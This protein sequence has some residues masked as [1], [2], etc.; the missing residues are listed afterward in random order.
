MNARPPLSATALFAPADTV[1]NQ[2]INR[3]CDILAVLTAAT[4][5][6]TGGLS[7]AINNKVTGAG[8]VNHP[9]QGTAP[10][11]DHGNPSLLSPTGTAEQQSHAAQHHLST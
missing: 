5:G 8:P 9:G 7:S 11:S 1:E 4:L 3:H 6:S 10:A 2:V